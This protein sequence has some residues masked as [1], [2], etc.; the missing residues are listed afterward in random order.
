MA[1]YDFLNVVFGPLL[2]LPLWLAILA[3][4][5]IISVIIIVITKYTT[6][7]TLMKDLKD[8]LKGHQKQIKEHKNNPSKA[9]EMQRKAMEVNMKYMS[10]SLRPTLITFIPIILIFGWMN[11]VFAFQSIQP[12]EQFSVTAAFDKN[13]AGIASI[14]APRELELIGS[15]NQT[16]QSGKA[17]W[18]LKGTKKGEVPFEISYNGETQE[19]KVLITD[20]SKYSEPVK[21]TKGQIKSIQINYRKLTVIPIGFRDW[22]GWL[23]TYIISSIIFT[24]G[25]RK[26]MKVY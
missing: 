24:M 4:S 13:A 10:H 11:S 17:T 3:M 1:Y 23:G 7:Q 9:M 22:L 14:S 16:I 19:H 25:L 6:N 15:A 21:K 5:F 18:N 8:Q 20:T 12:N 26:L 2:K